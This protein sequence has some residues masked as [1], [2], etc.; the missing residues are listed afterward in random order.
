MMI[1]DIG[2][3]KEGTKVKRYSYDHLEVWREMG[4]LRV[5]TKYQG[6]LGPSNWYSD[7]VCRVNAR[8]QVKKKLVVVTS[9]N[10]FLFTNKEI[11]KKCLPIIDLIKIIHNKQHNYLVLCTSRSRELLEVYRKEEMLL[12]LKQQMKRLGVK[13]H[14]IER[15]KFVK[16]DYFNNL[17]EFDP[18]SKKFGRYFNKTV[19]LGSKLGLVGLMKIDHDFFIFDSTK[20]IIGLLTDFGM[21]CFKKGSKDV[22]D[23]IPLADAEISKGPKTTQIEVRI[24]KDK[25]RQLIFV[26]QNERDLWFEKL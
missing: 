3:K 26:S 9:E 16:F 12:F 19:S 18:S 23:F 6:T 5:I 24:L 15:T 2:K 4:I 22:L 21:I 10:L 8:N 11:L 25:K 7:E 1:Q 14:L 13:F 17:Q 20:E